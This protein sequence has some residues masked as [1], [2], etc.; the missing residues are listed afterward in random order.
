MSVLPTVGVVPAVGVGAIEWVLAARP[1]K[2]TVAVLCV[3]V[4]IQER[5]DAPVAPF[6]TAAVFAGTQASSIRRSS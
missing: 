3:D 4:V 6:A 5:G 1:K 2:T